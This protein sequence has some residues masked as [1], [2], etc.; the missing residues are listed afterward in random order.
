MPSRSLVS[1]ALPRAGGVVDRISIRKLLGLDFIAV[2]VGGSL[3]LY[4]IRA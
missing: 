4:N 1:F 2:T 3:P